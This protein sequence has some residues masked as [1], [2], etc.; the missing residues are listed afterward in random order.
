MALIDFFSRWPGAIEPL[1]ALYRESQ[2]PVVRHASLLALASVPV[3]HISP[4]VQQQ[5]GPKLLDIYAS[6]EVAAERGPAE[7][8]LRRWNWELPP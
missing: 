1:L 3:E 5:I 7:L 4:T 2:N 8:I 6:S